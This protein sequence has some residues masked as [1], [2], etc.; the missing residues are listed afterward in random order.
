M[1]YALICTD[2]PGHLETRL[3]NRPAHV[4]WLESLGS[5]LTAAGPFLGPDEKPAGSLLI[6]EAA[7]RAA[8]ETLAAADPYANA[9]LFAHVDIRPW[10]WVFKNPEG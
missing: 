6:L 3:T 5:A 9:G 1:L 7:D 10:K 8:A 2:K 4:Q